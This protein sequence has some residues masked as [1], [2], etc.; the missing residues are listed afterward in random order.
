MEL[1][2]RQLQS[3]GISFLSRRVETTEG[4]NRELK[5]FA[6]HLVISDY[7][8]PTLDG[9]SGSPDRSRASPYGPSF[10]YRGLSRRTSG[11]E[12]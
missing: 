9:L 12:P 11:R 5:D 3:T 7:S 1:E 6:P 10:S 4:L 2:V 8:L